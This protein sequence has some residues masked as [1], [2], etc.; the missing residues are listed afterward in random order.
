MLG[1]ADWEV[2]L[3][4]PEIEW[5]KTL[6]FKINFLT[7]WSVSPS[8]CGS[9]VN[10]SL[11]FYEDVF[12][13]VFVCKTQSYWNNFFFLFFVPHLRPSCVFAVLWVCM[14]VHQHFIVHMSMIWSQVT[15][16]TWSIFVS[17]ITIECLCTSRCRWVF[18]KSLLS[19]FNVHLYEM[20]TS[21]HLFDGIGSKSMEI[22]P[23]IF[24]STCS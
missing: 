13:W 12:I 24:A 3:M 15:P 5:K 11:A 20:C 9:V 2:A 14:S 16:E 21:R 22:K 7:A 18:Q 8:M 23:S 17:A 4:E 6:L 1:L 10:H 19:S